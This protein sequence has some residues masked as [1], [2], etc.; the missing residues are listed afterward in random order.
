[1]ASR[2]NISDTLHSLQNML[3]AR[4]S[5]TQCFSLVTIKYHGKLIS[6]KHDAREVNAKLSGRL[7]L[8]LAVKAQA[9]NGGSFLAA[10][11]CAHMKH[12]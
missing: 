5:D 12:G 8:G 1:M 2:G 7:G 6:M 10:P 4:L 11:S 3:N 9:L